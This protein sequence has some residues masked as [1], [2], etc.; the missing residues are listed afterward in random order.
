MYSTLKHS[1]RERLPT[2]ANCNC[3]KHLDQLN[4]HNI[5]MCHTHAIKF[6]CHSA[7]VMKHIAHVKSQSNDTF[8]YRSRISPDVPSTTRGV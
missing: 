4:C 8:A 5:D 3:I 1:N 7:D 6:F 2:D